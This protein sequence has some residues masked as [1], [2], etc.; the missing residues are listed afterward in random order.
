M[1]TLAQN[2]LFR[3]QTPAVAPKTVRQIGHHQNN[4]ALGLADCF[5]PAFGKGHI[6]R[7]IFAHK[8][9]QT[10][11]RPFRISKNNPPQLFIFTQIIFQLAVY[12]PG[13]DTFVKRKIPR[14]NNARIRNSLII[15]NTQRRQPDNT[16]RHQ[17]SGKLLR[18]QIKQLRAH[19]TIS[20]SFGC[21]FNFQRLQPGSVVIGHAFGFGCRRLVNILA[22]ND[23]CRRQIIE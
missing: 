14:R 6:C 13:I 18:T 16:A 19:R 4:F 10:F 22:A 7:F 17:N 8:R 12:L 20:V 9:K 21:R 1:L 15:G 2:I 5:F 3:N 23:I 11:P